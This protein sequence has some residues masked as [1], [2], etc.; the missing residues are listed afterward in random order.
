M[1]LHTFHEPPPAALGLALEEFEAQFRYPLG[2]DATFAISHGREYI[3]FFSAIGDATLVVAEHQGRVLGTLAAAIRPVR[4]PDGTV[5]RVA[6]LGDL[7][8]TPS[9][10][11]GVVLGRIL[12]TMHEHL[13]IPSGGRAYGVVMDG[14]GR[15]P[16]SYTG[17]LAVPSFEPIA[18]STILQIP[19][20]L[21]ASAPAR[22]VTAD[23]FAGIAARLGP[24]GFVPIGGNALLRS[25]MIPV[26]LAND[27]ASGCIEDTRLAKRLLASPGVEIRAAHLSCFR[28]RTA[29]GGALLL[30]QAAVRCREVNIPMLF[31]AVPTALTPT[32]ITALGESAVRLAT[33]TVFG[34]GFGAETQDWWVDTAEI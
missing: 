7:K 34:C 18:Q 15:I 27:G 17:R 6:Y 10:R 9:A 19:T 2:T 28:F 16:P 32:L 13:A 14:T 11:G 8:V 4:F 26:Y 3:T 24:S 22:E 12:Q 1:T 21:A 30:R 20:T 31:V 23:E 29:K 25:Q 5:Q 33:A